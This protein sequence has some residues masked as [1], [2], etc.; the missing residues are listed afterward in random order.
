MEDTSVVTSGKINSTTTRFPEYFEELN[1]VCVFQGEPEPLYL[2]SM[3]PFLLSNEVTSGGSSRSRIGKMKATKGKG[4]QTKSGKSGKGKGKSASDY[5]ATF[6]VVDRFNVGM[7]NYS[8]SNTPYKMTQSLEALNTLASSTTLE[9]FTANLFRLSNLA[10]DASFQAVFDQYRI[11]EIEFYI[12]PNTKNLN[13]SNDAG[14]MTSVIDYDDA[15]NLT[16][17]ALANCYPNAIVTPGTLGHYHRFVPHIAVA[18]YSGAFTSFTNVAPQWIDIASD[19]VQHF[20][21]KTAWTATSVIMSYNID[22]R[23]HFEFRNVR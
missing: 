21:V 22:V 5:A 8:P 11:T 9:T 2:K 23:Y 4:K 10:N 7:N 17:V 13:T 19:S 15:T 16:S 18:A 6:S 3:R 12:I 20:G 1:S 14:L